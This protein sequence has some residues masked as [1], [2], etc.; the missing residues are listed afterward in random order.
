MSA[1]LN[2]LILNKG[3]LF[4]REGWVVKVSPCAL[5]DRL[6]A[7]TSFSFFSVSMVVMR[8][9]QVF[10]ENIF[11][12]D[13]RYNHDTCRGVMWCFPEHK[14]KS[15][16][17]LRIP[18]CFIAIQA[19]Y[20]LCSVCVCGF[21][22]ICVLVFNICIL[23]VVA[24]RKGTHLSPQGAFTISTQ[25]KVMNHSGWQVKKHRRLQHGSPFLSL[26]T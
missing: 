16:N 21:E 9:F 5:G 3:Q 22:I 17:F 11:H 14:K 24:R 7:T 20:W 1:A 19:V 23:W 13:V 12:F 4:N 6:L 15:V 2:V 25:Q 26:F 8:Y 18:L 10:F